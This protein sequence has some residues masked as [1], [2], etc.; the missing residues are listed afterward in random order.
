MSKTMTFL[1]GCQ[2]RV[3]LSHVALQDHDVAP[4]LRLGQLVGPDGERR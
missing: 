3:V 1:R 4:R 2:H